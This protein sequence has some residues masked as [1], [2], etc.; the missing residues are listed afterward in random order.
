MSGRTISVANNGAQPIT[1]TMPRLDAAQSPYV[2][3][4]V[5]RQSGPSPFEVVLAR[6]GCS[7]CTSSLNA[8]C[9]A[10]G[11]NCT[12]YVPF[13]DLP[14]DHPSGNW[15]ILI[16]NT[17]GASVFT[18]VVF[19]VPNNVGSVRLTNGTSSPLS[20]PPLSWVNAQWTLSMLL[21]FFPIIFSSIN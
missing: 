7:S 21:F 6:G 2:I 12:I 1:F 18:A 17:G 20:I 16:R 9:T 10:A 4:S 5:A 14:N 15:Q 13:C 3:V 8:T 11:A 19:A